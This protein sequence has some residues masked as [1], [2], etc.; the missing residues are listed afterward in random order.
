MALENRIAMW[1]DAQKRK[2]FVRE[3]SNLPFLSG[4]SK[5]EGAL[6]TR[7]RGDMLEM[8]FDQFVRPDKAESD[9]ASMARWQRAKRLWGTMIT[10]SRASYF[11]ELSTSKY[12]EWIG[13]GQ[14]TLLPLTYE[15]IERGN[16]NLIKLQGTETAVSQA[17]AVRATFLK[18]ADQHEES[19]A[20]LNIA[21]E[22]LQKLARLRHDLKYEMDTEWFLRNQPTEFFG[23]DEI[24]GDLLNTDAE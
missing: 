12:V 18:C 14:P 9:A 17:R 19:L 8:V 15:E 16:K 6:A 23:Y 22:M 20:H 21:D 5:E 1:M 10:E 7:L 3:T 24:F 13:G 2:A 11:V 4:F